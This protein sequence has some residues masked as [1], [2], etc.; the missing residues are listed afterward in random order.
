MS[1]HDVSIARTAPG[2]AASRETAFGRIVSAHDI[3]HALCD[4]VQLWLADYLAEVERQH[5]LDVGYLPLPRSY[6]VSSEIEKMPEDQTPAILVA[7]PGLTDPA[8]VAGDGIYSA[9]WRVLVAIHLSARGNA[10]SLRLVRL[11]VAALR[12]LLLQQQALTGYDVRR[13]DWTDERY[14]TLPSIDDRTVCVGLVELAVEIADVTTRHAGPLAPV[15]PPGQLGPDSP[16]WPSAEVVEIAIS[17]EPI[18]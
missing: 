17:K 11:Y 1:T 6:V 13:F 18:N 3:E 16:T 8:R 15:I 7:S 5:G 4:L 14:D 2:A 12:A 10:L 9:R